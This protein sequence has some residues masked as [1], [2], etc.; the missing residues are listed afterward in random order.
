[1]G[2][3]IVRPA[4]GAQGA[5]SAISL[6]LVEVIVEMKLL[7]TVLLVGSAL[8]QEFQKEA[9]PPL[10]CQRAEKAKNGDRI[11]M[12]YTGLLGDG[13]QFDRGSAEFVLGQE[14]GMDGQ[15]AG[16]KITMIVPPALGYGD[17]E[18]DKVP[19]SSTLYFLTTLNGIVRVTKAPLG[20]DCNEGQKARPGQDVTMRIKARVAS[21]DSRGKTFFDKASFE[22][23]FGKSNAIRF[24]RGLEIALTGACVDEKRTLFLGPNLAHGE[25]GKKDGSVKGG[26]SVIVEVEI[27]R[28]RN[29]KPEDKGLVLGFLDKISS[30]NLGS[31]AG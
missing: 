13:K 20:G 2:T 10:N 29:E 3:V 8:G 14:K 7:A 11:L 26:D 25:K 12:D 17:E 27:L 5:V 31:F 30:G 6:P 21:R 4:R 24:V 23:R 15:C 9:D 22:I 28:V 18:S 19:A 16:E 1:M